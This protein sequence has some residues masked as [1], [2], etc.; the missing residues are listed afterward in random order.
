LGS[1]PAVS[2]QVMWIAIF[3]DH[4]RRCTTLMINCAHIHKQEKRNTSS[5][6]HNVQQQ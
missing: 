5:L 1:F 2:G 3:K 4:A 6:I